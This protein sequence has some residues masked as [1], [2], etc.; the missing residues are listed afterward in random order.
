MFLHFCFCSWISVSAK[1]ASPKLVQISI[2]CGWRLSVSACLFLFLHF[3]FCR[4][5]IS[6]TCPD[7]HSLWLETPPTATCQ[8]PDQH[9]CSFSPLQNK[10]LYLYLLVT[11]L[12]FHSDHTTLAQCTIGQGPLKMFNSDL[13]T[14]CLILSASKYF[15]LI[16]LSFY[17]C[18]GQN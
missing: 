9:R 7:F 5:C 8:F 10:Y 1:S 3:C 16:S 14:L 11:F 13:L 4:I 2:S 15:K 6:K 18:R 17:I 12:D